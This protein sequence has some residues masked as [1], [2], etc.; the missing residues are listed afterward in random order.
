MATMM[1]EKPRAKKKSKEKRVTS[2]EMPEAVPSTSNVPLVEKSIASAQA[3]IV[4]D[5]VDIPFPL[6]VTEQDNVENTDLPSTSTHEQTV[7]SVNESAQ[8]ESLIETDQSSIPIAET[9]KIQSQI[10]SQGQSLDPTQSAY[11]D[12]CHSLDIVTLKDV[13]VSDLPIEELE[14]KLKESALA[15]ISQGTDH[16]QPVEETT[17]NVSTGVIENVAP[18]APIFE[19]SMISETPHELQTPNEVRLEKLQCIPLEVAMHI[20]GGKEMAE[21][22]EMS[23]REEALAEGGKQLR[24]EHPLVDLLSTYRCSA[25]ALE[26]EMEKVVKGYQDEEKS[27][28]ALWKVEKKTVSVTQKCGQ[29][30]RSISYTGTYE[31][32][33]LLKEKLP[34]AQLRLEGLLKDVNE[35]YCTYQHQALLAYYQ[36]EEFISE[37][38]RGNVGDIREALTLVLQELRASSSITC[39]K[40]DYFTDSLKR[41]ARALCGALL[42]KSDVRQLLFLLHQLFRQT[43]SVRWAA[44][45][46]RLPMCDTSDAARALAILDLMLS[47]PV[48][49]TAKECT[50]EN[51][52][53]WEEVDRHGGAGAVS[54]GALREQDLL[55]LLKALPLRA[56]AAR[57]ALLQR[58]S[59]MWEEVDRHGGA[60]AV[61]EGA[62][63]EQD[64]LALLKAFPLRALAARLALLQRTSEMWE[65]VDRHGGAGAVSEG[66][67]REQDLLALLKAFPLRALAARLALLQRTSEMWEEVDRHGGAG[68]VSEGALREQDLLALLKALPLRALAARLALLQR[69]SEMWEE[70]DRHGGAGAVSEGALREQDLLALLKAFPLR[71]L[72]ARLALLQRT[73]EMWEEV[74]RHGGAGAV[75]EGALREQDLLALLKAFPLRALAARLALLQRTSEMWEEVDRHGGAGAVSEGALRE[76]DLLALLKALPL[77]ALAARLALLQ[78]TSEMWE[79]VDRHGGAGAVSEGALR[80]Q[81]LLALLKAFPLRALAARLALLQRTSEMWEEVDRHGGAGA[82]SEGAL[83]EQDLLAL[84]KAFPLRALAARLALLQRTSEMWEEVD[85]HGGAGAVSEGAL[86]EQDLLALL[87]A[88]PLRAL[89]ARLALLQRTSEMWEEVDRHGGA[90]AVSEGALREQDLLALLKAFPLRALAARLALLQ[91]TSEMWEEVDRHGG[92]GAVSEGALREQDLLALLK[93]FPLRALAARLA[94]LQRTSEMWEEVDRHGGAGA[95]SEGA[96]R[97]QDL[98]ALLKALP[99]RALA[100]RLALL[101]RTSEMWEE[102]DRHGGAGAVSEGALR[103]QDLLALLKALPLRAL[104]ARLALLQRTD[105]TQTRPYEWDHVARDVVRACCGVRTLLAVITRAARTH[106]PYPRLRAELRALGHHA[107]WAVAD[108]HKHNRETYPKE[109]SIQI[110]AELEAIF[111]AGW[112]LETTEPSGCEAPPAA[113]LRSAQIEA[114]LEA[115]LI[116]GWLLEST[117]PSGCEA[118]PAAL[119]RSA[120]RQAYCVAL[121]THLH[122]KQPLAIDCLSLSLSLSC[123]QCVHVASQVASCEDSADIPA[124]VIDFLVQVALKPKRHCNGACLDA[125]RECLPELLSRHDYLYTRA[126]HSIAYVHQLEPLQPTAAILK[127][128]CLQRWRPS[129][130]EIRAVL[131]DWS[132]RS[133]QLL[134]CLLQELSY[135]PYDG[136]SLESQ[137]TIG[138]WLCGLPSPAPD[139]AWNVLVRLRVHRSSW[140]LPLDAPP[141]EYTQNIFAEAYAVLSSSW[142]HSLPLICEY[143]APALVRVAA[144]RAPVAAHALPLVMAAMMH[145]PAS[146]SLTPQFSSLTSTL[147]APP[148]SLVQWARGEKAATPDILLRR[149]L[150]HVENQPSPAD[151]EA[152]VSTWLQALC[153]TGLTGAPLAAADALLLTTPNYNIQEALKPEVISHLVYNAAHAS[154]TCASAL[155]AAHAQ[156]ELPILYPRLLQLLAEQRA[157]GQKIH[158]DNALK[159]EVISHLVY[160]AAHASL[161]CASALLAAHAQNEL[162]ILYPRLLQLLAEQRAHG[163]KIHVDNAL[164]QIGCGVTSDELVIHQTAAALLAPAG[165]PSLPLWRLLMYLYL[166]SSNISSDPAPIGPL[167][168]SGLVK[169]RTLAQLKK[170]LHETIL[171]HHNQYQTF[172]GLLNRPKPKSKSSSPETLPATSIGDLTGSESETDSEIDDVSENE[173]RRRVNVNMLAYHEG[174]EKM[175]REYSC[176]LE[177]GDRLRATPHHAD[178]A[179]FIPAAALNT[180]WAEHL[181]SIRPARSNEDDDLRAPRRPSSPEPPLTPLQSAVQRIFKIKDRSEKRA[182]ILEITS[183]VGDVDFDHPRQ[184]YM[185]VDKHLADV[186][187][188]ARQWSSDVNRVATLD[189]KLWPLV[190]SLRY[191]KTLPSV[192]KTCPNNCGVIVLDLQG[193]CEWPISENATRGLAENRSS[194]KTALRDLLRARPNEAKTVAALNT[195]ARRINSRET[196]VNVAQRVWACAGAVADCCA[197]HAALTGVLELLADRW[198]CSDNASLTALVPQWCAHASSPAQRALC[199][200]LLGRSHAGAHALYAALLRALCGARPLEPQRA[201]SYL[202]KFDLTRSV[203][204]AARGEMLEA[205]MGAAQRWGR[206]PDPDL[207]VLLEL[208]GVHIVNL[209]TAVQLPTVALN[210]ARAAAAGHLPPMSLGHVARTAAV[211]KHVPFDQLGHLLR[212]LGVL[213]WRARADLQT[214]SATYHESYAEHVAALQ[215]ALQRAFVAQGVALSYAPERVAAY[216]WSALQESWS[217]WVSP[218]PSLP[219]LL[220]AEPHAT[221][222]KQFLDNIHQCMLDCPGCEEHLLSQV[223]EWT[224]QVYLNVTSALTAARD[225][226]VQLSELL[227]ELGKLPW[228]EHQWP[229]ANCLPAAL[230]I[231]TS[232]D[233]EIQTWLADTLRGVEASTWLRGAQDCDIAPRLAALLQLF[234]GPLR[235]RTEF[236]TLGRLEASTWL[237]GAQD[238]DIAPR[239][240]ALLQLFA[241]PLR[242]R[243]ETLEQAVHLPWQ[244]LPE[245][246]LDQALQR[247]F[248][249]HHNPQHP[250]HDTPQ[251]RVILAASGLEPACAYARARR[252]CAVS[253]W[254]RAASAPALGGHVG[255]QAR[256]LLLL[257]AA[258]EPYVEESS[259]ELEELLSRAVVIMCME[260]AAAE[261][262]PVW[263]KWI[264]G[265]TP[266]MLRAMLS[267]ARALTTLDYF[268]SIADAA[269]AAFMNAG[270]TWGEIAARWRGC[271]CAEPGP[272]L[273]RGRLHAAYAL[274]QTQPFS[275]ID[276]TS[277]A[278]L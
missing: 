149:M 211:A 84:L 192:R 79:E 224:I 254:T 59:E 12:V 4:Q 13:P 111:I 73:S 251:F 34:A 127:P 181:N 64:L 8:K 193:S 151:R 189:T 128:F 221:M 163:Q 222:L 176:W 275:A 77:R 10:S 25:I 55:A 45:L 85:R 129:T 147:L 184:L 41:W 229:G 206:D 150:V 105:I 161:T 123:G 153:H 67:L 93:A 277:V 35:S 253:Q 180:A 23:E 174:A 49:E 271:A 276:L 5:K 249:D 109:L 113:L 274:A 233:L 212:E 11:K 17:E 186:E 266:R 245:M 103:E 185:L 54:E 92:A 89:A 102:V 16:I 44:P 91:R 173:E 125:A 9:S 241:G 97:E 158:V 63:R 124:M 230:Q 60:G 220:P 155:L 115:I 138:S 172:K 144:A 19:E 243:T 210:A 50:E 183:P 171:Y 208:L 2:T 75:S 239:L 18:S 22:R 58:T 56:L 182:Q 119:L 268:G 240:A 114:E 52:E 130:G 108:L 265:A 3:N 71:A 262:L 66:A 204:D 133:A 15:D 36:I 106:A 169:S 132:Q 140:R 69:T 194:A 179:R 272:L 28:A 74:D 148:Q 137:L 195:I 215:H 188:F 65:E 164:K 39:L 216:A 48:L 96:L 42:S 68:A 242:L 168:F 267:A 167:F 217:A 218:H 116:A 87:K 227:A 187:T 6:A 199:R 270:G 27:R 247:F 142:G 86:R 110:E 145:S 43:H 260:P 139:W 32:A 214:S 200:A 81:D 261:A 250:Y 78:R 231:S 136:L 190:S 159:V 252:A 122:E 213:W 225:S 223:W 273:Q 191:R 51:E 162:P 207:H 248:V 237:R 175:L 134:P 88:F 146:V 205:V 83:R 203:D 100:A 165:Y 156:N 198:I 228:S 112:L 117:E 177:A 196:A 70:V 256:E 7:L 209:T 269:A 238:C 99:L 76:Q 33:T 120:V 178:I 235:L 94:L 234:A 90:G 141:P 98:L 21:V 264:G 143:G 95:V 236:D 226:R 24:P 170:R 37:T 72:A 258:Q 202:S 244:R 20:F 278:N 80:E 14:T 40:M 107:M 219:P 47:A 57:L 135:T 26:Q 255:S 82:V 62:L 30:E 166:H 61:S 118:P 101:Q 157:H 46:I 246:A 29:C 263:V 259:D 53:M 1:K 121:M 160:N 31:H 257:L 38:V 126:V 152:A 154:L 197:A 104:A 131:D 201:F 232:I